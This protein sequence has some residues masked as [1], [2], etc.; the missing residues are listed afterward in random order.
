MRA[1]LRSRFGLALRARGLAAAVAASVALVAAPAARAETHD[2]IA[3]GGTARALRSA[4]ANAVTG[5]DLAGAA[6]WAA[7][8][9]G[10]DLGLELGDPL[11]DDPRGGPLRRLTVWAGAGVEMTS[12]RGTMFQSLSTRIEELAITGGLAVRYRIH[13]V[14]AAGA[15]L[16]IGAERARLAIT[17]RSATADDH[18]WTAIAS[19]TAAVDVTP[20][21]LSRFG[22]GVRAELGYVFSRGVALT[23]R[24]ERDGDAMPLPATE[25]SIGRLD[26]GGPSATLALLG[27]F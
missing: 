8:D 17:D 16:A 5:D 1:M 2:E 15:R 23:P 12:A 6:I 7:R 11:G 9:I 22:L 24:I 19:T 25:V 13:R 26:L 21:A 20:L 10:H 3:V 27:R 18:G 14:V 4:S